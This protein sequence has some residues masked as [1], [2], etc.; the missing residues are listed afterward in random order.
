V[1]LAW[2][3]APRT[4]TGQLVQKRV[5]VDLCA[6][7]CGEAGEAVG[8]VPLAKATPQPN[9]YPRIFDKPMDHAPPCNANI[10]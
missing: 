6:I 2:V 4:I 9:D 5:E 3:A 10:Q 8:A 1:P 7:F